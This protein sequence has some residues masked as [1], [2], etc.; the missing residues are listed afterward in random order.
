VQGEFRF[1]WQ[2]ETERELG[3]GDLRVRSRILR[4]GCKNARFP[5]KL[6]ASGKRPLPG[7]RSG[8]FGEAGDGGGFGV[9]D[10]EDGQ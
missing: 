3:L 8:A 1:P 7:L 2:S 9:V 6:R 5:S 10:V 4:A